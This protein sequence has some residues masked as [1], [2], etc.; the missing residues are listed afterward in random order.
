MCGVLGIFVT[1]K[2]AQNRDPDAN[3]L[4][5]NY[6]SALDHLAL[7]LVLPNIL[8]RPHL[9]LTSTAF[10][11]RCLQPSVWDLPPMLMWMLGYTNM[12]A[13]QGRETLIRNAKTH[14]R[15]RPHSL[16]CQSYC[17]PYS[18]ASHLPILAFPEGAFTNGRKGLLKFR[19][20]IHL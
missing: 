8:V 16:H 10:H 6:T 17:L 1:E 14:C 3:V 15:S 2:D 9:H 11:S 19:Y 12:G 13:K 4:V 20:T 18:L 7:D 5:A